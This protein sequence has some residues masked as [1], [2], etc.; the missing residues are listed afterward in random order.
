MKGA[1]AHHVV[2]PRRL[3]E[4]TPPVHKATR[5][6]SGL[7]VPLPPELHNEGENALHQHVHGVAVLPL[8]LATRALEIVSGNIGDDYLH[9]IDLLALA[10]ERAGDRA[11]TVEEKDICLMAA[12]SVIRQRSFVAQAYGN[13]GVFVLSEEAC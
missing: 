5:R 8:Y 6:Q 1:Q 4:S 7:I 9:N 10:Y 3:H 12:D 11:F 13:Q 2:F